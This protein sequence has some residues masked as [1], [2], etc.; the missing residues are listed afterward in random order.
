VKNSGKKAKKVLIEYPF[1]SSWKLIAPKEPTEKTRGMYRFAVDAQPGKPATLSIEEERVIKQQV[2][3]TNLDNNVIAIYLNSKVVGEPVKRA[4]EKIVERKRNLEKLVVQ[5]QK[6]EKKIA[7]IDQI[8]SRVR[9]NMQQLD[10]NSDLYRRY[11]TDLS[12]QENQLK[13][14]RDQIH[15][16]VDREQ[17]DRESLDQFLLELD[18]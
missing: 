15:D 6:L 14:L 10:R 3:I 17:K 4:L 16:L 18:V 9:Q 5:R 11:V 2:A 12:T 13:E 7:E 1:D 8:Q